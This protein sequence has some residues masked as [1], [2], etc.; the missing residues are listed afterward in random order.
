MPKPIL[1]N[2]VSRLCKKDE[3]LKTWCPNRQGKHVGCAVERLP[4]HPPFPTLHKSEA[5]RGLAAIADPDK[6]VSICR[7]YPANFATT[8]CI[9]PVKP[10]KKKTKKVNGV[11]QVTNALQVTSFPGDVLPI[12]CL[13]PW[14]Q[15][16]ILPTCEW[17]RSRPFS[18]MISSHFVST[19]PPLQNSPLDK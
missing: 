13:S 5:S 6:P 17:V 11:L 9:M 7:P 14:D 12:A 18:S 19:C 2:Y 16:D 1:K 3:E 8:R 10:D 15:H 4:Q